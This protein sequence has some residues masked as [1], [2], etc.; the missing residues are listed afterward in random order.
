MKIP[1]DKV[2]AEIKIQL[3]DKTY[4]MTDLPAYKGSYCRTIDLCIER[5]YIRKTIFN[6]NRF[7]HTWAIFYK[8]GRFSN[9]N[10]IIRHLCDNKACANI[11]HLEYGTNSENAIDSLKYHKGVK[12]TPENV[13]M[14]RD[15]NKSSKQLADELNFI[16]SC[17][18]R[19]VRNGK[20]WTHV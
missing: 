18:I 14:I 19:A 12:L 7:I 16:A 17:T 9:K 6:V 5:G 8:T 4:E 10:E 20:I 2:K 13:K 15:S 1:I 11:N 3:L